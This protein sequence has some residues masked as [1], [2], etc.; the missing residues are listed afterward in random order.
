MSAMP[1]RTP[2]P[3]PA[4]VPLFDSRRQF[5][6][7][8]DEVLAA[9]ERVCRSGRY[10]LGAECQQLEQAL[11]AYCGASHA[12]SC[13]SCSDAL[14]LALMAAGVCSGDE[15]LLPSYT[16]FATASAVWRLGAR[17]VFV[18]IEP[19]TYLLDPRKLAE[20]I[21][22]ATKVILPVHLFGQCAD[23]DAINDIARRYRLTVIEDAA[24]AIGAEYAGRRAGSL[25][26]I[27]CFSF[28][29]TKNLGCLGDGG[30]LTSNDEILADRLMLLRG[31]GMRPRYHHQEV[32]INS[33]LDSIQ[34]AVLL[35]KL[36]HLEQWTAQRGVNAARYREMFAACGL[37]GVLG[38]PAVAQGRRHVWN[39]YVI[40]VP[41]GQR[42]ALVTHLAQQNIGTEIYYPVPLHLQPCFQSLGCQP[43]S[44]PETERA[45]RETLALPI[46]PE[47]TADEQEQ[48]VGQIAAFFGS[49]RAARPTPP[50][51]KFLE[52]QAQD[53]LGRVLRRPAE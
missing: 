53:S 6:T 4:G 44:L 29:P 33:R 39:Q 30:L 7:I 22:P 28:Y 52:R 36:P 12:V 35:A 8:Q 43:G 14:L 1:D 31:H 50:R 13:A 3:A 26:D 16:F 25:A 17:P 41:D 20:Q 5:E 10:V 37:D 40:R 34:A 42:N 51:P 49:S 23:I 18:D 47:L 46:F 24:Q 15:V 38:L 48:V 11:S 27:G 32:G 19:E 2:A 9:V 45:A 21:T